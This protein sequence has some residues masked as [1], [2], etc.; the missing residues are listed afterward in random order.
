VSG[1]NGV[2]AQRRTEWTRIRGTRGRPDA[3]L[4]TSQPLRIGLPFPRGARRS[5]ADLVPELSG[6]RILESGWRV[7]AAWPDGSVKWALLEAL[8]EPSGTGPW[9]LIVEHDAAAAPTPPGRGGSA[10]V[11]A[12][13]DRLRSA[14]DGLGA[15]WELSEAA[16]AGI[17]VDVF[18]AAST[19]EEVRLR[20]CGPARREHG[21]TGS[22]LQLRGEIDVAGS[23]PR[24]QVE[25]CLREYPRIGLL[26]IDCTLRNPKAA[27][28]PGGL[29][30]LGDPNSLYFRELSLRLAPRGRPRI[31]A[32]AFRLAAQEPPRAA[33]RG[34]VGI[35]QAAAGPNSLRSSA[36]VDR[37]GRVNL[38]YA[39]C[40]VTSPL[41]S[42]ERDRVSPVLT[43][44]FG[45][46]EL[47]VAVERFWQQF[48]K[49]L[50]SDAATITA[51]LFP[52]LDGMVHELQPGE[53]KTHTIYARLRPAGAEPAGAGLEWVDE[54]LV[55][56]LDPE[57]TARTGTCPP[58]APADGAV[59]PRYAELVESCIT[60]PSSF[61]A[62]R[63][64][65]DEYGWRSFGD[66]YADHENAYCPVAG[67]IVSHFN[68]QY[69][70]IQGL[71]LQFLRTGRPEWKRLAEELARHVVDIDIYHTQLDKPAYSG[72]LFWH[73]DHYLPAE[74]CTHRTYS[75]DNLPRVA[76]TDYGGGPSNEH[77]YT[78]GLCL[79]YYLTGEERAKAAAVGLADWVLRMD[80]GR[81]GPFGAVDDG[82]TG[83]ASSTYSPDYHGPGRGAG[84][85]INACLDAFELTGQRVYLGKAETLL[86]RCFHPLDDFAALH[87]DDPESRWSYLVFLQAAGKYLDVKQGLGERDAS[88]HRTRAGLIAYARWMQAHERPYADRLDSVKYP[89]ETWPAHDL[90]KSVVFDFAA[91][92][93]P[94]AESSAFL[95]RAE[96]F[97]RAAL[98]G[99][100]RFST[101][102]YSRPL[103]IVLQNGHLRYG[104]QRLPPL[105]AS[106]LEDFTS[107]GAPSRF[108]SQKSRIRALAK[109]PAGLF[110]AARRALRPSS[111]GRALRRALAR[112]LP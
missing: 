72:G 41:G 89:T 102:M 82:P 7:L 62:K 64:V 105:D 31:D 103:A 28:H 77:N 15:V 85:S 50:S 99:L 81:L 51:G 38:P 110:R 59:D 32:V 96:H 22:S 111:H 56:S 18:F 26:R 92:Y 100:Y 73:T 8:I 6:G 20:R 42:L 74:R 95:E 24:P 90:R 9:E 109:S 98:D 54:P 55:F 1:A 53:Q 2:A 48:P 33:Q 21:P 34:P 19:G 44:A 13:P 108:V 27:H 49:S 17:E 71:W 36:H 101:R 80:D 84:N 23:R 16:G 87:L 88:Y 40:R 11:R 68:N 39:S 3:P 57:L 91:R 25:L 60:G 35:V 106:P 12:E 63:E 46:H 104:F 61:E 65:T 107:W 94:T 58:F 69:D 4:P 66:V 86:E 10:L 112:W 83:Q 52:P 29:W 78:S 70:V 43:H 37:S 47:S 79:T 75:A 5:L 67:P 76:R 45:G 30:D 97:H 14:H 93:A